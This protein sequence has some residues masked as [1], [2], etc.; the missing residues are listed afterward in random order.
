M[1]G[2][3]DAADDEPHP[4]MPHAT[5]GSQLNARASSFTSESIVKYDVGGSLIVEFCVGMVRCTDHGSKL[6]KTSFG[7]TTRCMNSVGKKKTKCQTTSARSA[8]LC[9]RR[10]RNR[11]QFMLTAGRKNTS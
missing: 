6:K 11:V 10:G 7:D 3:S 9:F 4:G 5:Y 8:C 1:N 2:V